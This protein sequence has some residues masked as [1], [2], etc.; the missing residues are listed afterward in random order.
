MSPS[1]RGSTQV[2]KPTVS[3]ISCLHCSDTETKKKKPLRETCRKELFPVTDVFLE[4]D[5]QSKHNDLQKLIEKNKALQL[6][7][8]LLKQNLST[9]FTKANNAIKNK[10]KR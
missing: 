4:C 9:I 8:E 3:P 7:N 2:V 1:N 10:A 5:W 6:E